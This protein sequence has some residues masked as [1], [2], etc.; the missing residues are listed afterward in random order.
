M[1]GT[2][3]KNFYEDDCLNSLPSAAV[4]AKHVEE[5]RLLMLKGGFNLTKWISSNREVLE[6]IPIGVEAD[7]VKELDLDN[8]SLLTERAFGVWLNG[9]PKLSQVS[10]DRCVKPKDVGRIV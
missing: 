4:A 6:S 9:L 10:G 5:L 7:G 3:M 1:V 8:D 2:V